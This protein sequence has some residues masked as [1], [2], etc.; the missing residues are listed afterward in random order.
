M[1]SRRT[2]ATLNN[3][4][5]VKNIFFVKT[6]KRN[7]NFPAKRKVKEKLWDGGTYIENFNTEK[8][9]LL[10][11]KKLFSHFKIKLNGQNHQQM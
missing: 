4:F 8:I 3:D 11:S 9:K 7:R 1:K 6:K 5:K 10:T 2:K